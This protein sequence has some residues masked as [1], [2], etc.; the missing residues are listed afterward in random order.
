M[1]LD[2]SPTVRSRLSVFGVIATLCLVACSNSSEKPSHSATSTTSATLSTPSTSASASASPADQR[3]CDAPDGLATRGQ[4]FS[5]TYTD[6]MKNG[7]QASGIQPS[8]LRDQLRML[9]TIGAPAGQTDG[10]AIINEASFKVR[11]AITHLIQDAERI[12][13]PYVESIIWPANGLTDIFYSFTDAVVECSD[14][15]YLVP[16]ME[17]TTPTS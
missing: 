1:G 4:P 3:V 17:R 14:A 5:T 13:P 16:W 10:S 6:V 8:V 2:T 7:Q 9:T 12:A 11:Q 15:G